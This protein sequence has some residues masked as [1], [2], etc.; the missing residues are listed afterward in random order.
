MKDA[1]KFL[2]LMLVGTFFVSSYL[3]RDLQNRVHELEK[4]KPVIIYQVDNAD[5][6]LIG[7][8]TEKS[9]VDGHY[10]VTIGAYGKFLVTKEQYDSINIGDNAPEYLTQRGG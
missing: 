9:I 1:V 2:S 7:T 5:G 8:V 10:T 3:I 4:R 6:N